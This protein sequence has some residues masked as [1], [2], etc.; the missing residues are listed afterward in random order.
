MKTLLLLFLCAVSAS[1]SSALVGYLSGSFGRL[2]EDKINFYSVRA[3]TEVFDT[4]VI[5]HNAEVEYATWD[6]KNQP[7]SLPSARGETRLF[8][9]NYRAV[10]AVLPT[11]HV[12][13]GAGAGEGRL[14]LTAPSGATAVRDHDTRFV[15]QVFGGGTLTVAPRI[16]LTAGVRYVK[17]DAEILGQ[18]NLVGG[19]TGV[20]AGLNV[21]F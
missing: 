12:T 21:R 9:A 4:T 20:E 6:R 18:K 15:W 2:I 17:F 11:V 10:A 7:F 5:S 8:L 13:A 16:D 19:N 3:G 1:T 14:E